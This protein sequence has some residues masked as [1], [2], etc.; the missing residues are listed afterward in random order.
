MKTKAVLIPVDRPTQNGRIYPKKMVEKMIS[1]FQEKIDSKQSIGYVGE[2][3]VL[4]NAACLVT[5]LSIENGSLVAEF[6]ILNT[7]MGN[8]VQELMT[9]GGEWTTLCSVQ[10]D[11]IKDNVVQNAELLSINLVR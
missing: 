2:V 4:T 10:M 8:K 9:I 6:D 7:P 11:D 3:A 1:E 5:S